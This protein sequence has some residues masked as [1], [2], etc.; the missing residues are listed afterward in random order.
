MHSFNATHL[1]GY[2]SST[3]ISTVHELVIIG[4][5]LEKVIFHTCYYMISYEGYF[6]ELEVFL[7]DEL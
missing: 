4:W 1:Q 2:S 3:H 6:K 7:E 5:Q